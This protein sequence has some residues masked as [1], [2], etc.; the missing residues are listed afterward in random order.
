MWFLETPSLNRNKLLY[1]CKI[2]WNKIVKR[3]EI[4]VLKGFGVVCVKFIVGEWCDILIIHRQQKRWENIYANKNIDFYS[5]VINIHSF[6]LKP[7]C[8]LEDHSTHE[9]HMGH[10]SLYNNYYVTKWETHNMATTRDEVA[11]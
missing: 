4:L 2:S 1:E 10:F 7:V 6:G 9:I 8:D 5:Y 11:F 3:I